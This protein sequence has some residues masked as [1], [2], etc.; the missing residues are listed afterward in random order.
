MR[1]ECR[2]HRL[3]LNEHGFSFAEVLV[4]GLILA[5]VVAGLLWA[6]VSS[7]RFTPAQLSR[8]VQSNFGREKLEELNE[9]VRQDWWSDTAKPLGVGAHSAETSGG[10]TRTYAVTTALNESK[11]YRKVVITVS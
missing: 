2:S 1:A 6:L 11:D 7:Q 5:G 3:L 8:S 4:G 10:N 9:S